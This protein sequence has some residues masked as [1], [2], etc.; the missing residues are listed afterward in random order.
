MI[1]IIDNHDGSADIKVKEDAV[2]GSK[3]VIYC[4][5]KVF[6]DTEEI[7]RIN[8][9]ITDKAYVNLSTHTI[10]YDL[11]KLPD[12]NTYLKVNTN[13]N[14]KA[15]EWNSSDENV[16]KLKKDEFGNVEVIPVKEGTAKVTATVDG[17]TDE[18]E[19]KVEK[20][21][22]KIYTSKQDIT[23]KESLEEEEYIIVN[24][25]TKLL[26]SSVNE[27][28]TADDAIDAT[29]EP[30]IKSSDEDIVRMYKDE[31][32]GTY[33]IL[34]ISEGEATL[35]ISSP[36]NEDVK[37]TIN[38]NV[39]PLKT[40]II[41]KITID[42]DE[43]EQEY[44]QG[45]KINI[46]IAFSEKID[47]DVPELQIGFGNKGSIGNPEFIQF[48]DDNTAIR[49]EYEVQEGDNGILNIIG[50]NGG[51]LTDDTGKMESILTVNS[52]INEELD[53]EEMITEIDDILE[54]EM[55]NSIDKD[56]NTIS[57]EKLESKQ[58]ENIETLD[59]NSLEG[60]EEVLDEKT[61][62]SGD[63]LIVPNGIHLFVGEVI[64]DTIAPEITVV[65]KIEKDS[66]YLN[67]GDIVRVNIT[68]NEDLAELPTVTIGGQEATVEGSGKEY[69]A[70]LEINDKI[71]EGYLEIKVSGCRDLSGNETNL[72]LMNEE[73]MDEPIVIDYSKP[74]I[75]TINIMAE[76]GKNYKV[77]DKVKIKVVFE[78]E[79]MKNRNEYIKAEEVPA[80]NIRFGRNKAEGN[81]ES[82]YTVGEYV[83]S[84]IYTY[85]I[86][87]KDI[88]KMT[89]N[90]IT[91]N[92]EDAAGNKTDLSKVNISN[93]ISGEINEIVKQ[94]D[95]NGNDNKDDNNKDNN[96]NDNKDDNNKDNNG[97][98]NNDDENKENNG[99]NNKTDNKES[100]SDKNNSN[101]INAN[102]KNNVN[103]SN[104]IK[105]SG[106]LPY[107][108]SVAF[109]IIIAS[110]GVGATIAGVSY[111]VRK[112]H[113]IK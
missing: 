35:E 17:I 112:K 93:V 77:G 73:N 82:D 19:V 54:E 30:I 109:W 6:S 75:K 66:Y 71:K 84:I 69:T 52:Q 104:N 24:S 56:S 108:G 25:I 10:N 74:A 5:A 9:E 48:E 80:L 29:E 14:N 97:N 12:T 78:D 40:P 28:Q 111:I 76:E 38:V 20:S 83:N 100:N 96:G 102:N 46:K 81:L 3:I 90:N 95:N 67:K 85:T 41:K 15:I 99:N 64:A 8:I 26:K 113:Y 22:T 63:G 70:S 106:K 7:A 13:L 59:M 103:N 50:L 105:Y 33:K 11:S 43:G 1:T 110:V 91:G 21:I 60:S 49:Y 51:S 89:I 57:D 65:P 98:N 4:K 18:C 79:N 31:E 62:S 45:E 34:A 55:E 2:I 47:G 39:K 107:T 42:Q 32:T 88:G 86:L 58:V 61:E 53:S 87:E 36:T 23:L 44:R 37:E 101:N 16:A 94:D 72:I 92:I 27:Q 68:S